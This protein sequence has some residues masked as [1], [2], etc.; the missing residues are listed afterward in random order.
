MKRTIALLALISSRIANATSPL[1]ATVPNGFTVAAV[2]DLIFT[3]PS[4]S[5][6]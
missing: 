2:G 4:E 1:D 6:K 5:H 3:Q